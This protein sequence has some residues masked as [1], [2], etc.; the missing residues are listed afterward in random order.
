MFIDESATR[1]MFASLH[2]QT[3]DR[4]LD[5]SVHQSTAENI[6]NILTRRLKVY[7]QHRCAIETP[8]KVLVFPLADP[9]RSLS[10]VTDLR[11]TINVAKHY[12]APKPSL[13]STRS[14]LRQLPSCISYRRPGRVSVASI[15]IGGRDGDT[16]SICYSSYSISLSSS[17]KTQVVILR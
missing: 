14:V 9:H 7:L 12:S 1:H 4:L 2:T 11:S 3:K 10:Y 8:F 17:S 15:Q 6:Y 5:T 16:S 13:S